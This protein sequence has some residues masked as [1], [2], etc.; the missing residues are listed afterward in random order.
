M[1]TYLT[2]II[3]LG[4]LSLAACG[5]DDTATPIQTVT[6]TASPSPTAIASSPT[7]TASPTATTAAP[8]P[9]GEIRIQRAVRT[10]QRVGGGRAVE[11][12][13]DRA[14]GQPVWYVTVRLADGTGSEVY[15]NRSTGD[16]V[17]QS[18]E[19]LN[20]V[21]RAAAPGLNATRAI[22]RAEN[23]SQ[24]G[25]A[26]EFELERFRGTTAW[27]VVTKGGATGNLEF[28][29]DANSGAVLRQERD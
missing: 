29:L 14:Q 23:I 17:G 15:I 2:P 27:Y 3:G 24:G 18:P 16:L 12:G 8:S 22:R 9:S 26:I 21:Q 4:V 19:N 25:T 13:R 28:Y 1:R 6:V 7:A 10:A 5:A 20:A 11:G